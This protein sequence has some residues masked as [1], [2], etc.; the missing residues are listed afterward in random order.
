MYRTCVPQKPGVMWAQFYDVKKLNSIIY[1]YDSGDFCYIGGLY[2]PCTVMLPK[3]YM[4][5]KLLYQN[6][7]KQSTAHLCVFRVGAGEY[8]QTS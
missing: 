7:A 4:L 8:S 6:A 2:Q 1:S 3:P 5:V